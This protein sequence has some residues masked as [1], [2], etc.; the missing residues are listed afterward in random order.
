[1]I[2]LVYID[3][4]VDPEVSYVTTIKASRARLPLLEVAKKALAHARRQGYKARPSAL[5]VW[6]G[7]KQITPERART[8]YVTDNQAV[9]VRSIKKI[10][11]GA[12]TKQWP[13]EA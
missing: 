11:K 2:A 8:T 4:T 1:M 3:A 6:V 12:S 9:L 13:L 10:K 7:L 5:E